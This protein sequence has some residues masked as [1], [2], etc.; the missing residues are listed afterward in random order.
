M[1]VY[2]I[3]KGCYSDYHICGVALD[4]AEAEKLCERCT[5]EWNNA[6]IEEYDTEDNA[7]VL[8]YKEIYSCRY[9]KENK[10]LDVCASECDTSEMNKVE[11]YGR[12]LLLYVGADDESE[13]LKKASD[14][15]AK[16]RA[17]KEGL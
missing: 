2:V 17:E 3:T 4:K 1:K 10:R 9:Y 14:I 13:A 12:M 6:Y 7:E 8:K 15:F 5:S 11:D 16:Y